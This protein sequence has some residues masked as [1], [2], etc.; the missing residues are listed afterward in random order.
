MEG[1]WQGRTGPA[2]H[3]QPPFVGPPKGGAPPKK[4]PA[5]VRV[6]ARPGPQ[7]LGAKSRFPFNFNFFRLYILNFFRGSCMLQRPGFFGGGAS[8]APP[9]FEACPY[10]WKC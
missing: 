5:M 7:Q 8:T 6:K 4:G 1:M 3:R 10:T 9:F 2:P